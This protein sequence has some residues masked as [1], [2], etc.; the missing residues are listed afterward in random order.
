M[1]FFKTDVIGIPQDQSFKEFLSKKGGKLLWTI[2]ILCVALALFHI[3]TSGYG[4]LSALRHRSLHV[5]VMIIII[6]LSTGLSAKNKSTLYFAF[7]MF[8]A[9]LSLITLFYVFPYADEIP[10][11]EGDPT[12]A[13]MIFGTLAIFLTLEATRRTVGVALSII[14]LVF[15]VYT[16]AG[17]WMPGWLGHASFTWSE[18]ISNQF[19]EAEGLWGTP[20]ATMATF[21]IIFLIFAGLLVETGML[22]IFV[23]LAIRLVGRQVGGAAKAAVIGSAIVGSLSGSAAA[24]TLIVGSAMLPGMKKAGFPDEEAGAIQA[25]A[26]TGAQ[27]MPPIM[28]AA[29]FIIATFLGIPY[30]MVCKGAIFPA[31]LYFFSFGVVCHYLAKKLHVKKLT[32][33]DIAAVTWKSIFERS[34]QLIPIILIVGLLV[35]GLSPMYAG[36]YATLSVIVISFFRKDTRFTLFRLIAALESGIRSAAL[37]TMACAAAGIVVGSIMQSGLGY[38][39]SSSLVTISHGSLLVLMPLVM[40]VSVMLG[41]GMT[42]VGVYI[43][44]AT[45]V[46]PAMIELGVEPIAAHLFPFYFG[47]IS[48]ITPPVAVA[49]YSVSGL[50]G[51]SP[52]NTGMKALK[53][54]LASLAIPFVMVTQPELCLIGTLPSIVVTITATAIGIFFIVPAVLGYME[55]DLRWYERVLMVAAGIMLFFPSIPLRIAGVAIAGVIFAIQRKVAKENLA[56]EAVSS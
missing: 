36:F 47:V 49:A 11:H 8:L 2:T 3:F 51:A 27:F 40:I 29:A 23:D 39:L 44:V 55:R 6:F 52:W 24:D 7:S 41:F 4:T 43:I 38:T 56:S 16:I 30:I 48:A 53:F 14:A 33:E 12:M 10:L 50:T 18:V 54:A 20:V 42:T 17:P 13:D 32:P 37:V 31:L 35:K 45:L 26:G 19:V 28:G 21:I 34:Y 22:R 5:L 9:L 25:G 1:S 46:S 15:M